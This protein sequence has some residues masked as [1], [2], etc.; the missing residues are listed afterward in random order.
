MI[1]REALIHNVDLAWTRESVQGNVPR[2]DLI[3]FTGE[4]VDR[5]FGIERE[6]ESELTVAEDSNGLT[7]ASC[8]NPALSKDPRTIFAAQL[9]PD[10]T[11][12]I[13]EFHRYKQT[14]HCGPRLAHIAG[15]RGCSAFVLNRSGSSFKHFVPIGGAAKEIS[16]AWTEP[17]ATIQRAVVA[18]AL[19]RLLEGNSLSDVLHSDNDRGYA[20]RKLMEMHCADDADVQH[21]ADAFLMST[22]RDSIRRHLETI[23]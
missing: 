17:L 10:K 8:E 9:A 22:I 13:V 2:R 16:V 14:T 21:P 6:R 5:L 11:T 12:F 1:E 19:L 18:K 20:R 15:I 3:D 4:C 7:V 23:E